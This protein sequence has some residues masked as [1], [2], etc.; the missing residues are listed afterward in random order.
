MRDVYDKKWKVKDETLHRILAEARGK[1]HAHQIRK[2]KEIIFPELM[3]S[4]GG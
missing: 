3:P 1:N 4:N 2:G